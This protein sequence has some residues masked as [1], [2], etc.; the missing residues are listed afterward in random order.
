MLKFSI[1]IGMLFPEVTFL[2]R[3]EACHSSGFKYVE[4]PF[5]Y[6]FDPFLL[7]DKM[8]KAKLELI[9]FDLPVNDWDSGG[10]GCAADPHAIDTFRDGLES[11][12]QYAS[13]LRPKYLTCI[14]GKRLPGIPYST[15][16]TVLI[17]NLRYA[18]DR[19]YPM[20][21]D[22]LVEIFNSHDN[23]DF[24][25][26]RVFDAFSLMD[27]VGKSNFKIQIDTYH[28]Q[29]ME[30]NLDLTIRQHINGVGH[31]QIG[32]LP[33]RHQPGTGEI[34]FTFLLGELERLGYQR[35]VGLEYIPLGSTREAL[36]WLKNYDLRSIDSGQ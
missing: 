17:N 26:T 8:Q 11:A 4:F 18:C 32:D 15:Q 31:I 7:K 10:R 14:A 12:I 20:G 21:I 2:D 19:L 22:L 34:D 24:F 33:G 25:I 28:V 35:Y 29:K 9:L 36:D 30:D 3:F 23:P 6:A 16:R 13:I 5:P 1:N 27:E